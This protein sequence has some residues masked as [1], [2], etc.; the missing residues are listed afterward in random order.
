MQHYLEPSFYLDY[1]APEVSDFAAS[2]CAGLDSPVK[3]AVSLYYAVRDQIKYD[4]YDLQYSRRAMRASH[5]VKKKSGF[6]VSK[7]VLLA[8]VARHQRIPSR[9]GFADVTNH[10]STIS[11]RKLMGTGLFIYHG[12]TEMLLEGKWVKAT[13][14]FNLS[15]C[16]RFNVRPLEFDGTEDSLFH[17]LDTLGRKHMEYVRDHGHFADLPFDRIFTAYDQTYP[18]LF[19]HFVKNKKADFAA[20]AKQEHR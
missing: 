2:A 3:K 7:A 4:P 12:Y 15:L 17:E 14:A 10:L 11:L 18:D 1:Y 9:L 13:P 19:K 5:V 16:T 20:E 6:C 8:A